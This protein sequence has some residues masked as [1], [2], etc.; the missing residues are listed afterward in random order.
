MMLVFAAVGTGYSGV[1]DTRLGTHC[2]TMPA[3]VEEC[4]AIVMSPAFRA[5]KEIDQW[6]TTFGTQIVYHGAHHYGASYPSGCWYNA[7]GNDIDVE[8]NPPGFE[9]K[10]AYCDLQAHCVCALAAP[11]GDNAPQIG[12]AARIEE[13]DSKP[14][15]AAPT[16]LPTQ[17]PTPEPTYTQYTYKLVKSRVC[18]D[19]NKAIGGIS[20]PAGLPGVIEFAKSMCDRSKEC[21]SVVED[22][23]KSITFSTTCTEERSHSYG[24]VEFKCNH[25]DCSDWD[26][27]EWCHCYEE[28]YDKIYA[29]ATCVG[30]DTCNCTED[31]S[32]SESESN[33]AVDLYVK[34]GGGK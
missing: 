3:T 26:C 1:I 32:E 9:E 11:K 27:P 13:Y 7:H 8:F 10:D 34:V 24:Q 29:D 6:I 23:G 30:E 31:E 19:N 18:D 28:K 2:N 20:L 22:P 33:D 17:S 14:P 15:S 4:E 5:L 21:V 16:R 25:V 12:N